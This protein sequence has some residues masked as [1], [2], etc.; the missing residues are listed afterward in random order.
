MHTVRSVYIYRNSV[1]Q[2]VHPLFSPSVSKSTNSWSMSDLAIQSINQSIILSARQ[3]MTETF[4]QPA[5]PLS[6]SIFIILHECFLLANVNH[7]NV[8]NIEQLGRL[9]NANN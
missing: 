5:S 9:P 8:L 1:S 4:S 2:L 6:E 3:S 7:V